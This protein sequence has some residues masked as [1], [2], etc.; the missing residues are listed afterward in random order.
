MYLYKYV[1][2]YYTYEH[3]HNV[4]PHDHGPVDITH[5]ITTQGSI[6]HDEHCETIL[7]LD[8]SYHYHDVNK[9]THATHHHKSAHEFQPKVHIHVYFYYHLSLRV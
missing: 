6:V 1:S 7:P 4:L 9:G 2:T 5:L 8:P 3:V